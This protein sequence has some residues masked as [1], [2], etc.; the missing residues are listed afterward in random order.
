[1]YAFLDCSSLE[2]VVIGSNVTSIGG[3]AF[4]GCSNLKS[5]YISDLS[6]WCKISFGYWTFS[7]PLRNGAKLYLNNIE[8]TELTIPSDI[9]EIKDYTFEGCKSITSLTIPDSLTSIG[10]C[11]FFDCS[12]LKSVTL[13][14]R[15]TLIGKDAFNSC[16]SLES[17]TIPDSV[18]SIGG[19]AFQNCFSLKEV[20]CK[21]TTP[22]SGNSD[23]FYNYVPDRKIYVPRASV[24][25]YKAAEYWRDYADDIEPYDFE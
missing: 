14:N 2:S 19:H 23:M 25:A 18:A 17:I 20:Y 16:S 3:S 22:P 10:E 4:I 15:V 13:G 7:N 12:N 8:V 11:A 9:T 5:V 21:P 1:M 6:A 24:D